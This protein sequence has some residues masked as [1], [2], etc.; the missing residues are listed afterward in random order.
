MHKF[1]FLTG[2]FYSMSMQSC[3]DID[4]CDRDKPAHNCAAMATCSD[5][6]GYFTCSCN[7]GFSGNGI[8]CDGK[9]VLLLPFLPAKM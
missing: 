5:Y 4:E 2:Y 7:E 1:D 6:D 3:R 8:T 9:T